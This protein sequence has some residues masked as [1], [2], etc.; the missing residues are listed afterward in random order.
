MELA[1]HA[2]VIVQTLVNDESLLKI[3]SVLSK[4]ESLSLYYL[5]RSTK[6][7]TASLRQRIML[8]VKKNLVLV[9]QSGSGQ[10]SL[11]LNVKTV[12]DV[13]YMPLYLETVRRKFSKLEVII[14][15]NMLLNISKIGIDERL[16][17]IFSKFGRGFWIGSDE[18]Y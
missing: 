8:L 14:V 17:W 16:W 9:E 5:R 3:V 15:H 6:M 1:K 18:E 2:E 4:H 12:E 7:E 13:L 10:M 11:K